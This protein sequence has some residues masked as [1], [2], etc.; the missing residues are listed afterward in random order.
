[1]KGWIRQLALALSL[2]MLVAACG[3]AEEIS[4]DGVGAGEV[5]LEGAVDP[6]GIDLQGL[7][8]EL[9]DMPG[10]PD[11]DLG[12][13]LPD[14]EGEDVAAVEP[15]GEPSANYSSEAWVDLQRRFAEATGYDRMITLYQSVYAGSEDSYL[16][17]PAGQEIDLDLNGYTLGRTLNSET[18]NGFVLV[19]LGKLTIR[20][21]TN[22][23]GLI[24]GGWND[25]YGGGIIVAEGG[26]VVLEGGNIKTNQAKRG[27]GVFVSDGGLFE[28]NGGKVTGNT[29]TDSGGG[30]FVAPGGELVTGY[31]E[32]SK[33]QAKYGGGVLVNDA[34][35]TMGPG[36]LMETTKITE[37]IAEYGGGVYLAGGASLQMEFGRIEGN[38]ADNDGGGVYMNSEAN[39]PSLT[40][41]TNSYISKNQAKLGAGVC[42][43]WGDIEMNGGQ[44][45]GNRGTNAGGVYLYNARMELNKGTLWE[46]IASNMGGGALVDKGSTL[47][48]QGGEIFEN[49]AGTGGG[50]MVGEGGTFE[51]TTEMLSANTA[52]AGGG[53]A[54]GTGGTFVMTG[55]SV[56]A[57]KATVGDGGG[58]YS[59]QGAEVRM[60]GGSIGSNEV[61]SGRAGGGGVFPGT[62]YVSG[63]PYIGGNYSGSSESNCALFYLE[64]DAHRIHVTGPL[65]SGAY[66]GVDYPWTGP[67][68]YPVTVGLG[69][70]GYLG[71]FFSNS[72]DYPVAWNY[73]HTEAELRPRGTDPQA[74]VKPETKVKLSQCKVTALKDMVYTGKALKPAVTV[75]YGSKA[76][77]KG[78]DYTVSYKNNKAVGLATVTVKGKGSYTGTKN[79]SFTI[80]PRAVAISKL[81]AGK[82]SLTVKWGRRAEATGYEL[83]YAMKSSFAGAKTVK[84]KKNATVS[85]TIKKLKTGK[86]YYVRLRSYKTVGKKTY[87]SAWSKGKGVK[88]K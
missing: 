81:T 75:K 77:K 86:T 80:L 51:L 38:Y 68:V 85:A 64:K 12:I 20:D 72:Y 28:L 2:A 70:G 36:M 45:G 57:N 9:E 52:D 6:E 37:N 76:L 22:G 23:A 32:I 8:P 78:T 17:V 53:V 44:I 56:R 4:I 40:M 83:Q 58:V 84:I 82:Q 88:V 19:V 61:P 35:M 74:P 16:V 1:M 60:S 65:Y 47:V 48:M 14:L 24:M 10:D 39:P 29:A 25:G 15:G 79:V 21:Y 27:G 67:G 59:W 7:E 87:Y 54:V 71:A 69:S 41:G 66:I 31:G 63:T 50:V 3:M 43:I 33:N 73:D 18:A 49:K 34:T 46:N 11:A 5:A 42:N 13:D 30:V 55:G 62:L 26:H